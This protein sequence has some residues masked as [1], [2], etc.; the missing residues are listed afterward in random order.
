MDAKTLP[1]MIPQ[2]ATQIG[3]TYYRDIGGG[4][5]VCTVGRAGL[6]ADGQAKSV[7]DAV[8]GGLRVFEEKRSAIERSQDTAAAEFAPITAM[9]K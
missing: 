8:L 7:T 5:W 3:L 6:Y 2:G 9:V 4:V 1:D